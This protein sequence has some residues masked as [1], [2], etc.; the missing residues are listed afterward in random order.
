MC[1]WLMWCS[2]DSHQSWTS[3]ARCSSLVGDVI[4][5]A[6]TRVC[7]T[8]SGCDVTR[9]TTAA[10]VSHV[11]SSFT[12]DFSIRHSHPVC[13]CSYYSALDLVFSCP[14][15][16]R[17]RLMHVLLWLEVFILAIFGLLL[18]CW[19]L[20]KSVNVCSVWTVNCRVLLFLVNYDIL[21]YC[22]STVILMNSLCKTEWS[23]VGHFIAVC[24]CIFFQ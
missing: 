22:K 3:A 17:H 19:K 11:F 10:A 7:H 24:V 20:L 2:G 18:H 9:Q 8:C 14:P 16:V 6:C 12:V 21:L 13:C 5:R 4:K 15:S 1:L 23:P